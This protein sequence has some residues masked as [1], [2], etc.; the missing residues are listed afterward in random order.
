MLRVDQ[1]LPAAQR[2]DAI[3]DEA[4][5][6]RD[7][8]RLS[9]RESEIYALDIDEEAEGDV[10]AF[11]ERRESDVVILH[12]ALPSPLTSAFAESKAKR[13]LVYHNITPAE[14][15]DR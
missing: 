12:F 13:V 8:L 5:R 4:V 6:I 15:L 11:S 1:W 10:L 7:V 2:G 9:G 3:G 14:F